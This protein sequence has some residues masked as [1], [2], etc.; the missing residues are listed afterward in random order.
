MLVYLQNS[1]IENIGK[2]KDE[3]E[4][5]TIKEY[6]V[7]QTTITFDIHLRMIHFSF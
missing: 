3:N 7:I 4:V 5:L 6:T 1:L 2:T